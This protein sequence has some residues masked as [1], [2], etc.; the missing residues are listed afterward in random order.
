MKFVL[1]ALLVCATALAARPFSEQQYSFLFSGFTQQ[2]GKNYEGE[3][4][5]HRYMTFRDNLDFVFETNNKKLGYE[6]AMNEFGDLTWREFREK[7]LSHK[8]ELPPRRHYVHFNNTQDLP[9]SVNWVGKSVTSAKNQQQCGSC[10]AFSAAGALEGAFL[11]KY[12][13]SKIDDYNLSE[14]E[15]VDCAGGKY[16]NSGCSGGLMDLAFDYVKDFKGLCLNKD[17]QYTARQGKC[18][19]S[20]CTHIAPIS[21]YGD[22]E[23][24]NEDQ[25]KAAV[26]QQPVSVAIEADQA[27]FQFYKSGVF[28]STCGT[29]LDHGVLVAGYGTEDGKDYWLVKNSWGTTWGDNGYIKILRG[30]GSGKPGLCGIAMYAS[31]PIVA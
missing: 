5:F 10:W 22:V 1:I 19:A 9:A 15:L 16:G 30:S 26:A 24:N 28:S 2:F 6:L 21:G 4:R 3:E 7:Y 23:D 17:Y 14:Q 20:K 8:L 27:S 11:I 31:F 12:P 18:S 25:L 29:Y 13:Q